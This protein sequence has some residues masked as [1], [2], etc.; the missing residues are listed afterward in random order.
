M[1]EDS[2]QN[3]NSFYLKPGGVKEEGLATDLPL[4]TFSQ[5]HGVE[6]QGIFQRT[7]GKQLVTQYADK[8]LAIAGFGGAVFIQHGSTLLMYPDA[9][10][11]A[12]TGEDYVPPAAPAAGGFYARIGA[13]VANRFMANVSYNSSGSTRQPGDFLGLALVI[14]GSDGFVAYW[15]AEF[16]TTST[17]YPNWSEVQF[18]NTTIVN[19]Y[20]DVDVTSLVNG[21]TTPPYAI[22]MVSVFNGETGIESD[23]L[24]LCHQYVSPVIQDDPGDAACTLTFGLINDYNMPF[25][26]LTGGTGHATADFNYYMQ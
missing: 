9:C 24:A 18:G 3:E 5:S 11:V 21:D 19:G 4:D 17:N 14:P 15:D 12:P 1:P 26:S 6:Q 20:F 10:A 7:P 13:A 2:V 23:N 22:G 25:I 8:V 16:L